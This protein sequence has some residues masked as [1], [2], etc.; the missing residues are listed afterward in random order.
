[1]VIKHFLGF[2]V[3]NFHE[4]GKGIGLLYI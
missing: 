2:C 1:M 4:K 3:S